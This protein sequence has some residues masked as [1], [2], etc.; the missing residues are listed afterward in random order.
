MTGVNFASMEIVTEPSVEKII[1][2]MFGVE[3][4][5]RQILERIIDEFIFD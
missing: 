3:E 1:E 4:D 5:D 2:D